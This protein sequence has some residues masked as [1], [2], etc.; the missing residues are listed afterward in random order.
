MKY[1]V[2][3]KLST[4]LFGR[5]RHRTPLESDAPTQA[6]EPLF[7]KDNTFDPGS[8][9]PDGAGGRVAACREPSGEIILI[10]TAFK[11]LRYYS[12]CE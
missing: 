7:D 4:F 11:L 6:G 1:I 9:S 2:Y 8:A 12:D 5:K 3:L 10:V